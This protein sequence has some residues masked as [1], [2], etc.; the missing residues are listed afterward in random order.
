MFLGVQSLPTVL[1]R[2]VGTGFR[3]NPKRK[4]K[5]RALC[6]FRCQAHCAKV[7]RHD[8]LAIYQFL[9]GLEEVVIRQLQ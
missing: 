3:I 8:A 6:R 5:T 1:D 2:K 9:W 7:L 4:Q